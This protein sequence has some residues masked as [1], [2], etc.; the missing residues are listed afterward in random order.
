MKILL[1]ENVD[2]RLKD[3]ILS[4]ENFSVKTTYDLGMSGKTDP[5]IMSIAGK[6]V[7]AILTHEDDFL[8]LSSELDE[9]P[10]MLYLPQNVHFREMKERFEYLSSNALTAENEIYFL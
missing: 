4:T 9:H 3:Y 10:S 8:S 1:D 2:N 6:E 7:L 5:E